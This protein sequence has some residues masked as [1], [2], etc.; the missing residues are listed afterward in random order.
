[1]STTAIAA[2]LLQQRTTTVP[3]GPRL[4]QVVP[5]QFGDWREVQLGPVQVDPSN[6]GEGD[7]SIDHP[8]D[9][10]LMR[11]YADAHGNIVLLALAYGRNQRQEIKIHR[12]D[13]C[14]TAQGFELV[15][16]T[17]VSMPLLTPAGR[18][19]S[20]TRML[21]KAPGRVEAVSYWIR[22][23]QAYSDNPWSL[24]YYIFTEGLKG[25]APD[26]V[27]VRASQIVGS[28]GPASSRQFEIQ[29][30]FLADLVRAIPPRA[31]RLLL[32]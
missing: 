7:P 13:V 5:R 27:L 28:N 24:R 11:A 3:E 9:D 20:G 23:G 17:R 4:E 15:S 8:Y 31:R 16:R 12:P 32:G 2:T 1:M 26:G 18:P 10:V 29:E 19:V 14:Y 22:V 30:R 21:F 6:P 25:R